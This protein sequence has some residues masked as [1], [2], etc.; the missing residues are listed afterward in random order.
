[1]IG[2]RPVEMWKSLGRNVEAGQEDLESVNNDTKVLGC[3]LNGQCSGICGEASYRG[4]CLTLAEHG[5][6][7]LKI[8]YDDLNGVINKL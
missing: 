6:D 7:D 1:M 5:I 8:N 4:N 2:C 3:G